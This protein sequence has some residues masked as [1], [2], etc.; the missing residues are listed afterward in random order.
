MQT[1]VKMGSNAKGG[2][3]SR[4]MNWRALT[5]KNKIENL[6]LV[7]SKRERERAMEIAINDSDSE[8]RLK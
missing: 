6:P 3:R 8:A 4:I 2:R 5:C 1:S 7:V